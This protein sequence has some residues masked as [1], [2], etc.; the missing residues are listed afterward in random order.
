[1]ARILLIDDDVT[2]ARMLTILL[3]RRGH[4]VQHTADAGAVV[5]LRIPT[6]ADVVVTDI[7]MP[8]VEGLETIRSLKAANPRRP[9]IAISG[10]SA[11]MPGFDPLRAARMMGADAVLVKPFEPAS[12]LATVEAL[13]GSVHVQAGS[14]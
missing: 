9:V 3:R 7:F 10:G 11:A 5:H 13:A 4:A 12:F 8:G 2:F 14:C 1:M 6:D